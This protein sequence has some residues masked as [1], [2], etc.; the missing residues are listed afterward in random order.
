MSERYNS[1][2]HVV[3]LLPVYVNR[4]TKFHQAQ[5]QPF[6]LFTA[7]KLGLGQIMS[8]LRISLPS[9]REEELHQHLANLK[10][11]HG[12]LSAIALPKIVKLV[13]EA[14]NKSSPGV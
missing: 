6:P 3:Q 5:I 9:V 11:D 10:K 1:S 8:E 2:T 7:P 12:Q 13:T 14:V 4:N